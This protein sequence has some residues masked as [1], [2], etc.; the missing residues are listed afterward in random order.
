MY[1]FSAPLV[2]DGKTKPMGIA[3]WQLCDITDPGLR[4]LLDADGV[5]RDRCDASIHPLLNVYKLTPNYRNEMA[6]IYL[7]L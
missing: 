4:Q 1:F 3:S 2:F 7:I 6:G 5:L